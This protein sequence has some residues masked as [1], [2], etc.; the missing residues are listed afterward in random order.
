[1]LTLGIL[2]SHT[3]SNTRAVVDACLDGRL[4]AAPAVI[5][6]NN[7][8]AAVL[9]YAEEVGVTGLRIGGKRYADPALRDDAI[10]DALQSRGVNLVL[11]LGYMKLLGPRTV[12]AY[13]G[14]ILNIHPALLPRHGGKGMY[15]MAVH[16]AV[17]AA[18]DAETGVTIHL[19]DEIYDNG[20]MLA[21]CRLPV[22]PGDT[23][24]SLAAR[25]L[26]REHS[27]LVE[28]LQALA[29]GELQLPG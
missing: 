2:S 18:G 13:R 29:A 17:I 15:G 12:A 5:V 16:E 14:R 21:Q 3:G 28:T 9:A 6:S 1:M 11:L 26:E 22:A 24:E 7:A 19:V 23:P 25:V 20:A 10:L 4:D 27:F 8:G